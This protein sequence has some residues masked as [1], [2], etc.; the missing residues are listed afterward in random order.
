MLG[1]A[2]LS[3]PHTNRGLVSLSICGNIVMITVLIPDINH[4]SQDIYNQIISAIQLYTLECTCGKKG[5]L[6]LY[7]HYTRIVKFMSEPI[8][9][10]VQ[11]VM[12]TECH[13]TH[14]LLPSLIV[15]YSQIPLDDQ[16]E[17]LEAVDSGQSPEPVMDRNLLIDENNV[18]YIVRQYRRH[19]E[20]RLLSIGK[21]LRD[22]LTVPCLQN[23]LRQ[24]MQIHRTRNKLYTFTNTA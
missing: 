11:R 3:L 13:T 17:I 18:K 1:Q 7:G 21:T 16:Q 8:L 12:C 24:F 20:Q 5:Y 2:I 10:S 9:L 22:S 19:W 14:A 6:I 15:P 23:Y 4:F